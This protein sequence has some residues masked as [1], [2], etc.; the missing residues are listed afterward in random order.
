[1][2]DD[3]RKLATQRWRENA[4]RQQQHDTARRLLAAFLFGIAI[5]LMVAMT[6][7]TT[8][9]TLFGPQ[10]DKVERALRQ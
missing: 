5:T 9:R 2:G 8:L 3:L 7:E 6:A 1:M 4:R 10:V